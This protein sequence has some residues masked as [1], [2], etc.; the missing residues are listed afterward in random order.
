[1]A[2]GQDKAGIVP[3]KVGH[4]VSPIIGM[5]VITGQKMSES[6]A[7]KQIFWLP[8]KGGSIFFGALLW[9]LP[10]N[11]VQESFL[12]VLLFVL[13]TWGLGIR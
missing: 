9:L 8:E 7:A 13:N 2:L 6:S 4:M 12:F 10:Q 3:A 11:G 1:M 5:L